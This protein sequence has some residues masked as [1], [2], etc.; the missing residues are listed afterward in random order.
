MYLDLTLSL[1]QAALIYLRLT[2]QIQS[3]WGLVMLPTI[4]W[5]V[6][7]VIVTTTDRKEK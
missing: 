1:T 7:G 2:E 5:A 6:V 4:I 3:S